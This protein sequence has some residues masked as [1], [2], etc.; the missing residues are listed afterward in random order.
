MLRKLVLI[1]V[2][3][4][5][6][7]LAT[8]GTP[9]AAASHPVRFVSIQADPPG[10]DDGSNDSLNQEWV[11]LKNY[12]SHAVKMGSYGVDVGKKEFDF[13]SGFTLQA[14]SRV[15]VHTG[16]GTN[17]R[18]DVYWGRTSYAYPNKTG[19]GVS[20]WGPGGIQNGQHVAELED[21]CMVLSSANGPC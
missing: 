11:V 20:L 10:T 5:A 4:V 8:G 9:V 2:T 13:P 18:H 14:G 3:A 21:T 12:S 19:Y 17:G 7:V 6:A 1:S 15:W 16:Q